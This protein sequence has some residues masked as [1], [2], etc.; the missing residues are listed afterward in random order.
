MIIHTVL[1]RGS[2]H[3]NFCQDAIAKGETEKLLY[4]AVFDGCSGGVDSHFASALFVKAFNK[5]MSTLNIIGNEDRPIETNVQMLLYFMSQKINQTKKIL[6]LEITELLS[7]IVL[8]AINKTTKECLVVA[9]GD[10][11]FHVDGA[12]VFIQNTR[13]LNKENGENMPDYMAYDLGKI[14]SYGDFENWFNSKSEVHKFKNVTNV[15]IASD[16]LGTFKQF[17]ACSEFV[18]PVDFLVK[19]ETMMDAKKMLEKKYNI[20]K[21]KYCLVNTDDLSLIR[22][23]L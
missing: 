18:N 8:C 2:D 13:F 5:V 3:H 23:K 4:L 7:T 9:F 21:N 15:S 12:E 6:H 16:G 14:E 17:K 22:I 1:R 11:Y 20:L 10:G 19:D